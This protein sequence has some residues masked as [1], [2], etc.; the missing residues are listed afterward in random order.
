MYHAHP[1]AHGTEGA[2]GTHTT[3]VMGLVGTADHGTC[4][5]LTNTAYLFTSDNIMIILSELRFAA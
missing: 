4:L 5:Y 3:T 2:V 1:D